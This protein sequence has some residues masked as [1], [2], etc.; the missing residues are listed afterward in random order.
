MFWIAWP[1][2][3]RPRGDD[4]SRT[5]AS[6]ALARRTQI[7]RSMLSF[8]SFRSLFLPSNMPRLRSLVGAGA[9]AA[10]VLATGCMA[11]PE[12]EER[13]GSASELTADEAL[14]SMWKHKLLSG[15]KPTRS[16]AWLGISSWSVYAV[17]EQK[18][19]DG[20]AFAG[21]MSLALDSRGQVVYAM[22]FDFATGVSAILEYTRRGPTGETPG[23]EAREIL[24]REQAELAGALKLRHPSGITLPAAPDAADCYIMLG[25]TALFVLGAGGAMLLAS[26]A[27][28]PLSVLAYFGLGAAPA[29]FATYVN[30]GFDRID[31]TCSDA[32]VW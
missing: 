28:A 4:R 10:S 13:D 2:S 1:T 21:T 30:D 8:E 31:R 5:R 17:R 12:V 20:Q 22:T 16:G 19:T 3:P 27:S 24:E 29:T 15:V 6:K 32:G 7:A 14:E 11:P 25:A 9:L 18:R 23:S 26:G